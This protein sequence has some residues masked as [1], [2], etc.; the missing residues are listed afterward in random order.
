MAFIAKCPREILDEA[1]VRSL[2]LLDP[3]AEF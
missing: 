2:A 3:Q 1:T